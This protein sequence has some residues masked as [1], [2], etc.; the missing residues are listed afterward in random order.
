[1]NRPM[2]KYVEKFEARDFAAG[3][4]NTR[5]FKRERY[6]QNDFLEYLSAYDLMQIEMDLGEDTG[7]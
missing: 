6:N 1:M 5:S 2:K 7:E 3:I 4:Y